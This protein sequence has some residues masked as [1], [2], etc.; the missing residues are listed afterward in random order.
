MNI[1]NSVSMTA[2]IMNVEPRVVLENEKICVHLTV[3]IAIPADYLNTDHVCQFEEACFPGACY[4][5]FEKEF[6]REK[7]LPISVYAL[8]RYYRMQEWVECKARDYSADIA[9]HAVEEFAESKN[10][11]YVKTA[12]AQLAGELFDE[13][14]A[15]FNLV[16]S[17]Y[18]LSQVWAAIA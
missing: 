12:L 13:L 3:K 14:K 5:F 9:K 7:E 1:I 18:D 10:N 2:R 16:F 6:D 15:D 17:M 11:F 4:G 8:E